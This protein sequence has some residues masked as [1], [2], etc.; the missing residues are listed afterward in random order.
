MFQVIEKRL[1]SE[2]QQPGLR[3]NNEQQQK[4]HHNVSSILKSIALV[5]YERQSTQLRQLA[6]NNQGKLSNY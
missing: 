2:N 6:H 1:D 4:Y 3:L 5:V